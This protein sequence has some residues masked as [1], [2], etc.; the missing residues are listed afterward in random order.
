[1]ALIAYFFTTGASTAILIG[2]V[3]NDGGMGPVDMSSAIIDELKANS[4]ITLAYLNEEEAEGAL[5]DK[6][7]DAVLIF[8]KSFTSDIV[9]SKKVRLD[10]ITEG[11]DQAKSMAANM[12]IHNA[13]ISA[14]TKLSQNASQ[15]MD[16][17]INS[18][19]LYA[20]GYSMIDLFAPNLIAIIAFVFVFIFTVVTFLR[21]RSFGTFERLLVSPVTRAE[22]ILGY[23]LGFSVFAIIQSSIILLFA[24]FVLN[25]KIEGDIYSVVAFQ[26]LLTIVSVNLG[27]FCSAFA[28]NELQAVQ[29]IP[30]IVVPQ[31][32][33]DGMFWPISTL[34]NYLQVFSYIIP[35]TYANHALQDIMVRGAG[36]MDVWIDVTVLCLFGLIMIVLSTL[37]LNKQLQ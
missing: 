23:M 13:T 21:E 19:V 15:K 32:F 8:G 33:L 14:I 5:K 27:I 20:E 30:L 9:L 26:L 37:S 3:D 22:I 1:M 35:L 2:V 29:F 31:V 28:K 36:L 12:N 6:K 25:V 24:L 10:I 18:E 7:V 11:T 16:V 34:P 17:K 4:N